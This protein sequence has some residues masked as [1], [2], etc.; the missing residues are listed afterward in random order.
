MAEQFA[1]FGE[2]GEHRFG[3]PVVQQ[4]G[5]GLPFIG[6]QGAIVLGDDME[7]N[8]AL[9]ALDGIQIAVPGNVGGLGRPRRNGADARRDEE[10]FASF[11]AS[12]LLF[13]Q[14]R[15]LGALVGIQGALLRHDMPVIGDHRFDIRHGRHQAGLQALQTEGGKG[16]VAL[17]AKNVGHWRGDFGLGGEAGI[18]PE[19]G[20]PPGFSGG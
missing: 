4:A 16:G 18:I 3:H 6:C 20:S 8:D 2:A 12:R 1:G 11:G 9:D 5:D 17:E 7:G 19:G 13:Q 14:R 10:Q 15:Q